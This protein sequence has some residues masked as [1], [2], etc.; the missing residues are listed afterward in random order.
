MGF[1]KDAKAL[2]DDAKKKRAEAKGAA[3]GSSPKKEKTKEELEKEEKV[4]AE[5]TQKAEQVKKDEGILSKKEEELNDEEKKRKGELLDIKKKEDEKIL[6]TPDD[7]LDDAGKK[8]KADIKAKKPSKLELR[9]HGLVDEIG[10][11]KKDKEKSA[12]KDT[13]IKILES[14]LV[15]VKKTLSMT[16]D[17]LFNKK[18]KEERALRISKQIEE[19]KDKPREERREMSNEALN[20]WLDEDRAGAQRW[21]SRNELNRTIEDDAYREMFSSAKKRKEL[22]DKQKPF[23]DKVLT[24][25]PELDIGEREKA[26][27]TEGKEPEE[28]HK[29][30]LE[31]NEKYRLCTEIVKENPKKYLTTDNGPE[32]VMVEMEKRLSGVGTKKEEASRLDVLEKKLSDVLAENERLRNLDVSI[33]SNRSAEPINEEIELGKKLKNLASEV[34]LPVDKVL[35]RIKTRELKGHGR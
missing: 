2:L 33:T 31:E 23:S 19:D 25:H 11:L 20:E 1:E 34:G 17:D 14:E 7:R 22:S 9:V 32:L 15:D 13:R 28:I 35:A 16:P 30:L 12:D 6:S 10:K 27:K 4:K 8:R 3:P 24:K 18:V 29:I 26:L 21:I 5:E